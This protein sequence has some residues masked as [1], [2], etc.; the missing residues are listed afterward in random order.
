MSEIFEFRKKVNSLDKELYLKDEIIEK[1]KKDKNI[2]RKNFENKLEEKENELK[3][4]KIEYKNFISENNKKNKVE[5]IKEPPTNKKKVRK[6]K[7]KTRRRKR[8]DSSEESFEEMK[9]YL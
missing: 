1:I 2:L 7:K 6:V 9:K 5:E 3:L 8:K 4:I